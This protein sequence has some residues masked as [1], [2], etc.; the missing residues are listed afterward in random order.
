MNLWGIL[1]KRIHI[2]NGEVFNEWFSSQ[3]QEKSIPFCEAMMSK[4]VKGLPF[5]KEFVVHRASELGVSVSDYLEKMNPFLEIIDHLSQIDEL[6]LWFG[7]DAFCQMNLLTI[8]KTLESKGYQGKIKAV[9][10]DENEPWENSLKKEKKEISLETFQGLYE[11]V[12]LERKHAI[13]KDEMM[14][15]GIELFLDLHHEQGRVMRVIQSHLHLDE[16][17]LL[18][19]IMEE[20]KQ[21]GLSDVQALQMIKKAKKLQNCSQ[22]T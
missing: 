18:E 15:R 6:V 5:E 21:E 22:T 2:T 20:T 7:V 1:M 8:L 17:N 16:E 4:T 3:V 14:Q 11:T 19:L 13:C 9:L 12:L 10:F